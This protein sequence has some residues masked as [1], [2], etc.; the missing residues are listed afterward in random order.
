MLRTQS[1]YPLITADFVNS[2]RSKFSSMYKFIVEL[3]IA[4]A[5]SRVPQF[6][7]VNFNAT[8]SLYPKFII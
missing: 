5:S 3:S 2:F 6:K 8:D 7:N 4:L 1:L